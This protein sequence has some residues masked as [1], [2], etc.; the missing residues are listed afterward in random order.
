MNIWTVF[1]NTSDEQLPDKSKFF[2]SLKDELIS[3]KYYSYVINVQNMLD[4]KNM[5]DYNDI[6]FK[7]DILLLADVFEELAY[8][9]NNMDQILVISPCSP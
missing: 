6:Y 7:T 8:V 3:E 5:D 4:K 9:Q 1:K 2:T